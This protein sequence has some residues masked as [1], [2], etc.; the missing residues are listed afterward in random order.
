MTR[1]TDN[2]AAKRH[3]AAEVNI[4]RDSE[5]VELDDLWDLLEALLELRNLLEVVAELDDRR[6]LKH[7]LRVD[8]ELAVLKRVN[9]TLDEEQVRAALDG[10]E[11]ATGDIDTVCVVK[12]LDGVTGGGLKLNDS[13]PVI[14]R[15]RVY[16]DVEL[17]ALTLHD[18]L[19]RCRTNSVDAQPVHNDV[20]TSKVD[21][22]VVRVEDLELAN[23]RRHEVAYMHRRGLT[24]Q[25]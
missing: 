18:P 5:M 19:E 6:G 24:H 9:V 11:A 12:V 4:A 14:G 21:P 10:Q 17:H 16:D 22:Q 13:L 3:V 2:C 25:T 20:L 7:A 1:H 23:W 15:L 8:R